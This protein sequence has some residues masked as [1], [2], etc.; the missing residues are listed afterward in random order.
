[1]NRKISYKYKYH[2][3][4]TIY[5]YADVLVEATAK[6]LGDSL[7]EELRKGTL[8]VKFTKVDG[9][10]RTMICTLRED[11]IPVVT[12][13]ETKRLNH[14]LS[15]EV[16]RVYDLEKEAWRSFRIDSIKSVREV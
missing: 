12:A 14:Q 6:A 1:M 16:V 3:I 7:K 11:L 10:E 13:S 2:Y 4:M 15:D 8:E 9:E 5:E